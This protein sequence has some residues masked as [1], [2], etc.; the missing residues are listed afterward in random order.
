MILCEHFAT[1]K[2]ILVKVNYKQ[3]LEEFAKKIIFLRNFSQDFDS[4]K[5]VVQR[6]ATDWKEYCT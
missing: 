1:M 2:R 6:V 5:I 3:L 4:W